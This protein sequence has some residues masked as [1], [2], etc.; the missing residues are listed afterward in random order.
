VKVGGRGGADLIA[1]EDGLPDLAVR[2]GESAKEDAH[3]VGALDVDDRHLALGVLGLLLLL[4][5]TRIPHRH[6]HHE[7]TTTTTA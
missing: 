4:S 6:H 3:V 7:F 5:H 2:D 1:G